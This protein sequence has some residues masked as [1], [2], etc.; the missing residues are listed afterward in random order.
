MSFY[1]DMGV[2]Q[3][4]SAEE[5]R[6]Q[7]RVLVR[8]FH[9]DQFSDP[10]LK[11]AS[12][13]QLRR[14]NEIEAVLTDPASRREY[15]FTLLNA[16]SGPPI[17]I[18]ALHPVRM[19]RKVPW[20]SLAW[21]AAAMACAGAIVWVSDHE[22]PAPPVHELHQTGSPGETARQ[23]VNNEDWRARA[24]V[25]AA[26]RDQALREVARLKGSPVES[27][28]LPPAPAATASS[29]AVEPFAIT[30]APSPAQAAEVRSTEKR[31]E[32]IWFYT[33]KGTLNPKLY[34]PEFIETQISERN[35][36][37]RGHYRSRYR[38]TDRAISPSVNFEFSGAAAGTSA[39]LPFI[40]DDGAHGEV[41]LRLISDHEMEL[42]W[43]SSGTASPSLTSGTAVLMRAQ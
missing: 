16:K 5:V 19:E 26:E 21:G 35:G 6:E 34:A 36:Q 30:P 38:V 24:R 12:E 27:K 25:V 37:V 8:L 28:P 13:G 40:R 20:G 2:R 11:A 39:Q 23:A 3:G 33:R 14:F 7:Y 10:V 17:V 15:D 22:S 32:G 29:P 4:A 1:E 41:R 31:F 42:A 9:P 18:H 43:T